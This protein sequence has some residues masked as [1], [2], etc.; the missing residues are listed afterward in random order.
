ML[1]LI[2]WLTKTKEG[3]DGL[4]TEKLGVNSQNKIDKQ[5][6]IQIICWSSQREINMTEANIIGA[7]TVPMLHHKKG[8]LI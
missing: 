4:L 5:F 6:L 8:W 1:D 7:L 2:T 3:S